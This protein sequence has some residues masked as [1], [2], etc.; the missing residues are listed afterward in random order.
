MKLNLVSIIL[1]T[2]NRASLVQESIMSILK[3]SYSHFELIIIDDGSTDETETVIKGLDDR[4]IKYFKLEHSGHTGKLKNFAIRQAS[5]N[6]IA[7]NDSD[8]MWKE[9]KLEK[10][11]KLF[12]DCPSIGF[13]ITDVTTFNQDKIL[14]PQSYKPTNTIECRNIFDWL[15]DSKFLV[16]NPTLVA[17]KECFQKAGAFDESMIS[18]DYHFNLRLAHYFEAG[19]I[20]EPLVWRR[21]H[22]SNMSERFVFENYQEYIATFELLFRNKWIEEKHLRAAKS[23]ACYKMA[24]LFE[25]EGKPAKARKQYLRSIQQRWFHV[26]SYLGVLKTFIGIR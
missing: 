23:I 24:R 21:V 12:S 26:D 5:G 19:I 14:I 6:F 1:L 17:K 13:S 4:R 16:Y 15:R 11:M 25:K 20:Y 10:Q 2:Y 18:G 3:Q 22:E 7:F 8:D 9:E